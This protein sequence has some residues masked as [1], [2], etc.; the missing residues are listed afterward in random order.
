M[1]HRRFWK[2]RSITLALSGL[3]L[4]GAGLFLLSTPTPVQSQTAESTEPAPS[5][6]TEPSPQAGADYVG[7]D[8]CRSCHR[9]VATDHADTRHA[10]TLQEAKPKN[11]T[12]DFDQGEDVRMVQ[13]PGEDA[14]RAFTMD[15]LAYVVGSGRNVQRFLY[16]VDRN[17]Y[18]VL[19]AEWNVAEGKWEPYTPAESWDDPAYDWNQSC[20]GC[21]TTGLNADRGR[22]KDDGVQC[23]DCHGP[24]SVHVDTAQDVGRNPTDEEIAQIRAA[25]TVS[26]DAQVC[27]ACHSQG[28]DPNTQRPYSTDY[29]PGDDLSQYLTFSMPDD[30]AHWSSSEHA[31]SQNMQYN[32]W[33]HSGHANALQSMEGSDYADPT[34]LECHSGD[35]R[36][37]EQLITETEQR[38]PR[39]HRARSGH[40]RRR[41]STASPALPAT[42]CTPTSR[43][44][45]S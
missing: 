17:E 8:E 13:F 5:A 3:L 31:N 16:E 2:Y 19:P 20:A 7:A 23:E 28:V 33:L 45:T 38:R 36:L 21:H 14:P 4:I 9:S 37:T 42:R 27:G 11:I 32:E 40:A 26:A 30:S 43:S 29:R 18:R 39:R 15:D 25:I 35:Y 10:L 22:W 12:A 34:C 41:R 44:I 6:T 24:G 1:N